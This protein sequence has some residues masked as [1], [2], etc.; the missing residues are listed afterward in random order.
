MESA[1]FSALR[2]PQ[3]QDS[4]QFRV[5]R[6]AHFVSRLSR[7]PSC[8]SGASR[9]PVPLPGAELA[10]LPPRRLCGHD[11]ADLLVWCPEPAREVA[12]PKHLKGALIMLWCKDCPRCN[13]DLVN[14][15]DIYGEFISCLQ[16]G[17]ILNKRQGGT[18]RR[19][20]KPPH[21]REYISDLVPPS[22]TAR[23]RRAGRMIGAGECSP[24][25][26]R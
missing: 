4:R 17:F 19:E 6:G 7:Q 8:S 10:P 14:Q 20:T 21:R 23:H 11:G 12:G 18:T 16:C 9:R 22:A 1:F 26:E 24:R 25:E 2:L 3:Y 13:G 5:L 15:S